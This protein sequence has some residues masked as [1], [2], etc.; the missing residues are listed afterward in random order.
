MKSIAIDPQGQL[1]IDKG[2]KSPNRQCLGALDRTQVSQ[3]LTYSVSTC[4]S[5]ATNNSLTIVRESVPFRSDQL[6]C[7][8]GILLGSLGV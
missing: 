6:R 7:Y 8:R 4:S 2:H 1:G 3:D 5:W